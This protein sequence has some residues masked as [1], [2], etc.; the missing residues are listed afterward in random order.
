MEKSKR[1]GSHF[2]SSNE[3]IFVILSFFVL[4]VIQDPHVDCLRTIAGS[5]QGCLGLVE[6]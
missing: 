5:K 1:L 6:T 4:G 3:L 2:P